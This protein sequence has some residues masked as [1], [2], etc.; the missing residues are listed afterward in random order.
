[1]RN[2]IVNADDFALSMACSAGIVDAFKRGAVTSSSML[3]TGGF[4]AQAAALAKEAEI[5]LGLHLCLTYGRP[6]APPEKIRSLLDGK[7]FF[8]GADRLRREKPAAGEVEIE[9]R[10][11]L[12]RL[13]SLG[14]R[15]DHLDSHHF[16][17]ERLG[18]EIEDIAIALAR[19]L[20]VPLRRTVAASENRYRQIRSPDFFFGGFYG[21]QATLEQILAL[22]AVPWEGTLE[23]MCHPGR[24]DDELGGI[25]SYSLGRQNEL[26]IL[27]SPRIRAA[28][29]A[30][31][32]NLVSFAAL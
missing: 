30:Q 9:W 17:H 19:E 6:A 28:A 31:G 26:E 7:G 14:I 2:L 21:G 23:L 4:P 1:M 8:K 32:I 18:E 22:L 10:A 25:S 3:V 11:Q 12:G 13:L 27:L 24:A 20:N 16:I 29:R 5:P 15:P